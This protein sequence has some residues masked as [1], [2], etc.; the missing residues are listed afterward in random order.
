MPKKAKVG[1]ERRDHYYELA[2]LQGFR[3]RSAFK[4]IQLSQKHN[5]FHKCTSLIDLCAA[6]GGWLQVAQQ[7][8]PMASTIIGVDLVPIRSI[9]GCITI[10]SDITS[11]QCRSLLRRHVDAVGVDLVL[12]DGAPNVG[13]NWARD[14]YVQNELTLHAA[15]LATEFLKPGGTFLTK[16][17]RSQ[18]YTSLL[19]ILKKLFT[20]VTATKPQSSR[21]QSAEIFVVCADFTAPASIDPK[22]FDPKYAFLSVDSGEGGNPIREDGGTGNNVEQLSSVREILR[23]RGAKNR[24]GYEEGD[25]FSTCSA[26]VFMNSSNPAQLITKHN[27]LLLDTSDC[28]R[29]LDNARTTEEV[30]ALCDDLKVCGRSDLTVLM[31]WRFRLLRD[32]AAERKTKLNEKGEDDIH[33]EASLANRTPDEVEHFDEARAEKELESMVGEESEMW[34]KAERKRRAK[35]RKTE[36]RAKLTAGAFPQ[37]DEIPGLFNMEEHGPILAMQ[38]ELDV[39]PD[40]LVDSDDGDVLIAPS[41]TY[42]SQVGKEG[43]MDHLA[44]MELDLDM[45]HRAQKTRDARRNAAPYQI[46]GVAVTRRK[47]VMMARTEELKEFEANV[48]ARARELYWS[49]EGKGADSSDSEDEDFVTGN[50]SLPPATNKAGDIDGVDSEEE[51]LEDIDVLDAVKSAAM[52]KRKRGGDAIDLASA[53]RAEAVKRVRA[54]RWFANPLFSNVQSGTEANSKSNTT[55]QIEEADSTAAPGE[56]DIEDDTHH[57]NEHDTVAGEDESFPVLPLCDRKKK[58]IKRRKEK[59]RLDAKKNKTDDLKGLGDVDNLFEKQPFEEV[60]RFEAP[61]DP[62]DLAQTRAMGWLLSKKTTRM[63]LIDSAYNKYAFNDD[64]ETLPEW[65]LDDEKKHNTPEVPLPRDLE[66]EFRKKIKEI[67]DRPIRK[68]LEA[69]ARK[70]KH[71]EQRMARVN[72]QA[73]VIANSSELSEGAQL[74]SIRKIVSKAKRA[75]KRPK[76]YLVQGGNG[77]ARVYRRHADAPKN[78]VVKVVDRRMKADKRGARATKKRK[79][80]TGHRS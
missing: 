50:D 53:Q 49:K 38:D 47:R 54:E 17:F 37:S 66:A 46:P 34:R 42:M 44:S 10:Q 67:S 63:E 73:N 11:P 59:E 74:K 5:I 25:D 6:P 76:K 78:A 41:E 24:G 35:V 8:M 7:N 56:S 30:K 75:D 45:A 51:V 1:K 32:W 52:N 48:T 9:K 71:S 40:D 64:M 29:I 26:M 22:F 62:K 2:K 57:K 4:L 13:A 72:K 18:D 36:Y 19:W 79:A 12:H 21:D 39:D 77:G 23:A 28:Q 69:K 20:R 31:R 16:V 68:V 61:K 70:K 58:Q 27:K 60:P 43:E 33:M 15:K 80:H 65:F 55:E 14:A 3:A